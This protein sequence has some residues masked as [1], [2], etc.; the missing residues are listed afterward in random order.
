[1]VLQEYDSDDYLS[2]EEDICPLCAEEMDSS[3]KRFKPCPCGYQI[4]QF[5]YNNIREN[6]ELNGRC[7]AC[8]RKYRDEDVEYIELTEAE[9]KAE[10]S[11]KA[12]RDKEK[13]QK[14]K[15]RREHENAS[16]KHLADMRVIQKNLVYV[17][18]LNPPVTPEELQPTLRSER[19]FGQYG[20]ILKLVINKRNQNANS[21][22]N[23]GYGIYVTYS[24]TE[25]AD[26]CIRAI[27]GS[28]MDGRV[29]RAAYG[30]TKYCSSYL[31]GLPCPNP[32]CMFLHEPGEE[33]DSFN[34]QDMSTHQGNELGRHR[35]GGI[36]RYGAHGGKDGNVHDSLHENDHEHNRVGLPPTASWA[37]NI[38]T[39]NSQ[40]N[41]PKPKNAT[42][43]NVSAFPTLAETALQ[44]SNNSGT[45]LHTITHKEKRRDKSSN[46]NKD[47][48][49]DN[50][51]DLVLNEASSTKFMSQTL[52]MLQTGFEN[53]DYE[54]KTDSFKERFHDDP[55][56]FEQLFVFLP[57]ENLQEPA[58]DEEIDY[59]IVGTKLVDSI[60]LN[61]RAED[62]FMTNGTSKINA[63][64]A[65]EAINITSG[66]I[67]SNA[68]PPP[69]LVGSKPFLEGHHQNSHSSE[70]L[71]HLLNGKKN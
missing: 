34:R 6:P 25:D 7:P 62:Y 71:N 40:N 12:N 26:R 64:D 59:L 51:D 54:F 8:R 57:Q 48:L 53:I 15:E 63:T 31:R 22:G 67:V 4:C 49:R 41:S 29:I 36:I 50:I 27:D 30:T 60:I 65:N 9:I 23:T 52:Q 11:R 19:Y 2:D 55:D 58:K 3:D 66:T 70:I 28:I 16:R 39:G 35:E 56:S 5:C 10:S 42:L 21:V 38:G 43:A 17:V 61:T 45:N 24:K 32:N 69:G 37:K 46:A 44:G 14:E 1:M 18:G 68:I 47:K 20:K 13:K 33:A